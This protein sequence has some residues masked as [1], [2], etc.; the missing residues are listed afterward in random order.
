MCLVLYL[1]LTKK[2]FFFDY[3]HTQKIAQQITTGSDN[4][5]HQHSHSQYHNRE[6]LVHRSPTNILESAENGSNFSS[7]STTN[8]QQDPNLTLE[9][10]NLAKDI[11]RTLTLLSDLINTKMSPNAQYTNNA[12]HALLVKRYREIVYDCTNDFRKVNRGI[13]KKREQNE[14]FRGSYNE[15]GG[16]GGSNVDGGNGNDDPAMVALM[17]ER[18]AIGNSLQSA[19]N[20]I[21]QASDVR[22]ELR[23]QGNALKN[24]GG[25]VLAMAG[26]VPG[27][28]GL[29]EGIRR[30]RGKD[31]MIVSC[32]IAACILFTL[33][34]VLG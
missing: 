27:L 30:K 6:S 19:S 10:T 7:S 20:V 15:R 12:H 8:T 17:R 9:E 31:D 22:A 25:K 34:Y 24:V 4:D 29:I 32:V 2:N 14:L 18:N 28:N 26:R 21:N 11:N 13:M 23:N 33:W 1:F 16:V 5:P 3:T